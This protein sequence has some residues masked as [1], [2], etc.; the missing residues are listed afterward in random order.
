MGGGN[1]AEYTEIP[2]VAEM[3]LFFVGVMKVKKKQKQPKQCNGC[4]W[5]TWAGTVQVCGFHRCVR[6]RMVG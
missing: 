1:G 5:G 2:G 4:I 3:R 6:D